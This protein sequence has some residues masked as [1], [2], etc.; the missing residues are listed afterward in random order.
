M[1]QWI[2]HIS[3]LLQ[4]GML[5]IHEPQSPLTLVSEEGYD[6]RSQCILYYERN[7]LVIR[8]TE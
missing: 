3:V 6:S 2:Y 4:V 5:M 8:S 7:V 1:E